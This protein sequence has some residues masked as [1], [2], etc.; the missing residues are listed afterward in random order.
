MKF[1][2]TPDAKGN[3]F[4]ERGNT[5]TVAPATA[6]KDFADEA[7]FAAAFKLTPRALYIARQTKLGA[8]QRGLDQTLAAGA[9]V[10]RADGTTKVKLAITPEAQAQWQRAIAGA[11][12]AEK[13]GATDAM[14]YA[15]AIGRPV[16]DFDGKPIEGC[17]LGEFFSLMVQAMKAIATAEGVLLA[18]QA[19][20]AAAQTVE[21]VNAI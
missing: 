15:Q 11:Q 7:T 13:A 9:E 4:T 20:V 8:L 17:T 16:T 2:I 21:A 19:A 12:L 14:L 1:Q 5:L 3:Y 18:K 10:T 6:G